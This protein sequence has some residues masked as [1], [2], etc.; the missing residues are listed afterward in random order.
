MIPRFQLRDTL[1]KI[2][3]NPDFWLIAVYYAIVDATAD[4]NRIILREAFDQYGVT[5]KMAG[6][7]GFISAVVCIVAINSCGVCS[8]RIRQI[9]LLLLIS[10]IGTLFILGLTLI[11][12]KLESAYGLM[13]T[14]PALTLSIKYASPL[15]YELVSEI[16][17]PV[18]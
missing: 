13:L 10:G 6:I 2:F 18:S 4:V 11:F 14:T 5:S 15:V 12:I 9:K 17:F 7:A 16:C 8:S 3:K 1:P